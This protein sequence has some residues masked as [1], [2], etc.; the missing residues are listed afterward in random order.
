MLKRIRYIV[1]YYA[2]LVVAFILAKPLFLYFNSDSNHQFTTNDIA[3]V[4]GHGLVL[5]GAT[6][7]YLTVIPWLLLTLSVWIRIPSL[8]RIY[9]VWYGLTA[10]TVA[11]IC[12]ADTCLYS[13]WDFKLD[14]TVLNYIDSPKNAIASVS[15]LYILL[16]LAVITATASALF[17]LL[18]SLTPKTFVPLKSLRLRIG[19]SLLMLL[20]GGLLFL[21]IRGGIGKST[22]NIG[23]VYYSENQYL[24]HAA[25]NPAFSLFYSMGKTENF[26]DNCNFYPEPVRKEL[27]EALGYNTESQT[28]DTLLRTRRPHVLIILMEGFGASFVGELGGTPGITPQFDRLCREGILF[29]QCYGNSYRTDRGTVCALSGYPSFPNVSVMK[30][31]QKSRTLPS[32]ASSLLQAGYKTDFVYGGDINFTNMQSYLR[33]TGYQD[34]TGDTRFSAEERKTHAWG[35]TDRIM[36]DYLA[37]ELG[38]RSGQAQPWHTTFLTLASHEPWTVP[39]DRIR[40]DEKGNA[41]AYL[42]DCLGRFVDRMKKEPFWK[43]LLIVCLPDHA[44]AYPH[45]LTTADKRRF[46][47]P[48]LWLGGAL[49]RTGRIDKLCNQTDLAATLLGQM[50]LPHNDFRFSR[51]IT[52]ASYRYP[53]AQFTFGNG[54]GWIDSTGYT[55]SDLSSGRTVKAEPTASARRDSLSRALLQTTFDDLGER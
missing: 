16:A 40:N 19:G 31:P 10:F 21:A 43:D 36:F 5:D 8:R 46:Q 35:V 2:T 49:A 9:C 51:D 32:L 6:A 52:S 3:D 26:A 37:D 23:M 17:F 15:T 25:V 55:V 30:L 48:M 41:M 22:A 20:A 38:R 29:T 14:A 44:I 47:I 50:G 42:D 54:F 39:Y 18:K 7:A 12:V 27:F 13:F 11:L 34:V 1:S 53:S 45:T 24:N 4:I 33:S 28:T